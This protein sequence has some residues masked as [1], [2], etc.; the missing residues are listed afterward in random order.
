MRVLVTKEPPA[1]WTVYCRPYSWLLNL[2]RWY[3][4]GNMMKIKT[5]IKKIVLSINSRSCLQ[6]S[7][8]SKRTFKIKIMKIIL[9]SQISKPLMLVQ[10]IWQHLSSG[11]IE[12]QC[13][14]MMFKNFAFSYLMLSKQ[15]LSKMEYMELS[16]IFIKE[17]TMIL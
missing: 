2:D 6:I 16:V 15:V 8:W 10:K 12:M 5:P 3:I 1:T 17:Q 4:S 14:N 11:V 9:K 13:S 7:N